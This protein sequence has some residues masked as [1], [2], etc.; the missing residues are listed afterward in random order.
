MPFLPLN[1]NPLTFF[2]NSTLAATTS[3][4]NVALGALGEALLVQNDGSVTVFVAL[5]T[6]SGVTAV[7]GGSTTVSDAGSV[8]ILAG[9]S[10]LLRCAPGVTHLAGI[11]LSGTSVIR[12]SRGD[13]FQ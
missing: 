4:A 8:P 7:T 13:G 5:G 2:Q 1:Q 3:S 12:A 10:I 11:T 6:S 9:K